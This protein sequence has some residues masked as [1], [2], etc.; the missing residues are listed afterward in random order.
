M[1]EYRE[2]IIIEDNYNVNGPYEGIID[3]TGSSYFQSDWTS[4]Q[5][6]LVGTLTSSTG[7]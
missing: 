1:N 6:Q 5:V 2:R 4:D 7:L 3:P